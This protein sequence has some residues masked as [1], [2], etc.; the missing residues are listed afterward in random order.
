[1]LDSPTVAGSHTHVPL[2]IDGAA[3]TSGR[4]AVPSEGCEEVVDVSLPEALVAEGAR[5]QGLAPCEEPSAS[6]PST[7]RAVAEGACMGPCCPTP[8]WSIAQRWFHDVRSGSARGGRWV[9]GA[10]TRQEPEVPSGASSR[11]GSRYQLG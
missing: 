11:L 2:Q 8:P 10:S 9:R 5:L 1:L 7:A 6:T 3:P 4:S